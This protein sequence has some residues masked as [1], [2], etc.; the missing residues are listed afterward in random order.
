[1]G[2]HK[3]LTYIEILLIV[4]IIAILVVWLFP[5]ILKTFNSNTSTIGTLKS[6][7]S[8]ISD[9]RDSS[10]PVEPGYALESFQISVVQV[11]GMASLPLGN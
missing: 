7:M 4:A 10:G 6:N 3:R 11:S 2:K 1:M 9:H 5:R 8:V